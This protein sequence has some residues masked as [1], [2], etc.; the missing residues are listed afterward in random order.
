MAARKKAPAKKAPA[1]KPRAKKPPEPSPDN[2]VPEFDGSKLPDNGG[3]R[4]VSTFGFDPNTLVDIARNGTPLAHAAR[5]LEIDYDSLEE[6]AKE[7]FNRLYERGLAE[8][9]NQAFHGLRRAARIGD[10]TA[11]KMYFEYVGL[12]PTGDS[13]S[14]GTG[15]NGAR[16]R[17]QVIV[18]SDDGEQ[19][20]VET[21]GG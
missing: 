11:A 4:F 3:K 2:L 15:G 9:V 1:R 19:T 7:F 8:G 16:R 20:T 10:T 21:A 14:G 12:Q 6:E 17:V 13:P 18:T 5:L